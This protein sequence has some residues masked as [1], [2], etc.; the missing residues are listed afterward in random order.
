[1]NHLCQC[2]LC[3]YLVHLVLTCDVDM[4]AG[5]ERLDKTGVMYLTVARRHNR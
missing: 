5:P 1:M 2:R 3:G 4:V